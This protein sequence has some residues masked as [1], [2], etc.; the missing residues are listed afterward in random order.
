MICTLAHPAGFSACVSCPEVLQIMVRSVCQWDIQQRERVVSSSLKSKQCRGVIIR[1]RKLR[2][3]KLEAIEFL[4]SVVKS[5][6][7][8]SV[9]T[10]GRAE[11]RATNLSCHTQAWRPIL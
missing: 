2:E 7:T 10:Q 3:V 5:N 11:H 1:L 6:C 4:L 9:E 8:V